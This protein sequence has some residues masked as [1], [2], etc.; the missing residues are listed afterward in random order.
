MGKAANVSDLLKGQ[1][2]VPV[3]IIENESQAIGL[4]QALIDGG[5][6]VIEVTLRNDYGMKA[7]ELIKQRYPDMLVL[8]GT[9][10]T[11]A[12][13]VA[14]IEAGADG[15]VSP[16]ITTKL[17]ETA[18]QQTIPYLPGVSSAS[19]VLLAMEYGLTECKLFPATVVGGMS[20][21]KAFKSPFSTIQFCPT[22][23]VNENNFKEFL[24]LPNV[25]CVG[26]SWVSP[27]D[28]I[29][30]ENW[31]EITRLCKNAVA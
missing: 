30:S 16:G 15:I 12:Q 13:M 25:M 2:I 31:G 8:A 6:N 17:L 7:I 11:S 9:V 5:I 23:G 10:N 1:K 18:Q 21:L 26:G 22:G 24:A 3:V 14:V 29:E 28:L 19:D 27:T 20:A 4:A